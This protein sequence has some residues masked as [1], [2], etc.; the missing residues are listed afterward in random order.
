M[1]FKYAL[2]DIAAAKAE[3]TTVVVEFRGSDPRVDDHRD[4]T[5][6][7]DGGDARAAR[8]FVDQLNKLLAARR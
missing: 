3:G 8:S 6:D 1:Q 7:F 5:F 4:H 2:E